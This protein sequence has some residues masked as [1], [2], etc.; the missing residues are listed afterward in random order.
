MSQSLKVIFLKY[1]CTNTTQSYQANNS[2]YRQ[3][4]SLKAGTGDVCSRARTWTFI[5]R[6]RETLIEFFQYLLPALQFSKI[7]EGCWKFPRSKSQ[8]INF[9]ISYNNSAAM[10]F[11][12]LLFLFI[13][14][15]YLLIINTIIQKYYCECESTILLAKDVYLERLSACLSS[16]PF[17]SV[18]NSDCM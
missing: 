17:P 13:R 4:F 7:N 5:G 10:P 11:F 14:N 16:F 15:S 18:F 6:E 9:T 1:G 2:S 3:E 8:F 12:Q